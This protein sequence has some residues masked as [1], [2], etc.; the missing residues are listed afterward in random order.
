MA[1]AFASILGCGACKIRS[2]GGEKGVLKIS[3]FFGGYGD[4]WAQALADGYRKYN[5]SVKVEV[6]CNTLVRDE[7]VT[8]AQ[9]NETDTDIYFID[10]IGVGQYCEAY[11]SLA[12]LSEVYSSAPKAGDETEETTIAEKIRPEIVSE[13]QYGGDQADFAG[14]YYTV[15]SPSGPCSL[16]LNE[17]A[18]DNAL[19]KGK[20]EEPRTT[21]EL[22]ALCDRIKEAEA[23]VTVA[24]VAPEYWTIN[25]VQPITPDCAEYLT[26]VAF[27]M[28]HKWNDDYSAILRLMKERT[29]NRKDLKI[30]MIP[31]TMNYRGDKT[32][33]HCIEH[34]EK[35]YEVLK[36]EENPGGLMCF[37][38]YTFK[39]EEEDLGNIGLDKLGDPMYN[40]YWKGLVERVRTIGKEISS[41]KFDEM[42]LRRRAEKQ[43]GKE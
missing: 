6:V 30:W 28:Y 22:F 2:S 4:T 7:A 1:T 32:E 18:L 41:G 43:S 37:T 29:G 19:G 23:K 36:N 33:E 39:T 3:S 8:A 5:P 14:K 15:P 20:W 40:K 21:N 13:M 16:I 38:Y 34:L 17:D 31:C 9:T 24:G 26:D 10:G 25:N 11:G 12:D 35:C 42:R 27:D